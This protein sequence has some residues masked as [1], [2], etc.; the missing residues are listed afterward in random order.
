MPP[1]PPS[2]FRHWIFQYHLPH[3]NP[4]RCAQAIQKWQTYDKFHYY[5]VLLFQVVDAAKEHMLT[6]TTERSVYWEAC[7]SSLQAVKDNCTSGG[8][9]SLPAPG[10]MVSPV[11]NDINILYSFDMAQQVYFKSSTY[12]PIH[13]CIISVTH[14]SLAQ[15]ISWPP[16]MCS[17]WD[18]VK[19]YTM[20]GRI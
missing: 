8:S 11:S 16:D 7:K 3:I 1:V 4:N 15:C 6:V 14:F 19:S 17:V 18:M 12:F 9:F 13:R 10:S 5:N 20:P 2:G